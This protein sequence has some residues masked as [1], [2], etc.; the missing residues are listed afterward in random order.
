MTQGFFVAIWFV[1]A[2]V[3]R[4][5]FGGKVGSFGGNVEHSCV[6]TCT[7]SARG[8]EKVWMHNTGLFHGNM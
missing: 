1:L 5:L 2:A 7:K 8:I 6:R 4:R 3:F